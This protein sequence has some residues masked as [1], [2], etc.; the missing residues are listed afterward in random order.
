MQV[1]TVTIILTPN[2]MASSSLS[3]ESLDHDDFDLLNRRS[4]VKAGGRNRATQVYCKHESVE[5]TDDKDVD[6]EDYFVKSGS[7]SQMEDVQT[8]TSSTDHV[9]S[10]SPGSVLFAYDHESPTRA[11]MKDKRSGWPGHL[12]KAKPPVKDKRKLR[13]KRR[14]SG[15]V[16]VQ[17]TEVC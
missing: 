13:E 7:M 4:R 9:V 17:S 2:S 12:H 1:D 5:T 10:F 8:M 11:K 3:Q 16:H 6:D 15:L 14:S